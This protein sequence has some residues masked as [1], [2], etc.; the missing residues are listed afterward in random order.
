MSTT[1]GGQVETKITFQACDAAYDMLRTGIAKP[2]K[3]GVTVLLL[4]V[5]LAIRP[6]LV[7][8]GSKAL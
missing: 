3:M 7:L 2:R 6:H 4:P 5:I 1:L 8:C